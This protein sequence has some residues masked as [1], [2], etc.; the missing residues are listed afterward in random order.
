MLATQPV[1]RVRRVVGAPVVAV[2]VWLAGGARV[3]ALPGQA[4][5][6]GRLLAE[7]TRRRDW[8]RIADEAEAR[9]MAIS[10][11]GG[12]ETHGVA[13]DALAADWE[14]AL[15]WA[16]ELTLEP[17]FPEDRCRWLGR[18][19]A[20]ELESLGDQPEVK[21]AWGFLRQLYHPH[22]RALPLHGTAEGLT[23]LTGADC[24]AFHQPALGRRLIV[25]AAGDLD[26]DAVAARIEALFAEAVTPAAPETTGGE[27][28]EGADPAP[29][30]GLAESRLE[31]A[32]E[33]SGDADDAD[34]ADDAA[35]DEDGAPQA[36]L[37][38]GHLTVPRRHPDYEAL[39]LAAVVLGSGAGLTGRIPERIREREGLAYSTH[40]QTVSGA[41]L[42]PGRLVAYVGTSVATVEQA[43][44]GVR[45]EIARLVGEGIT[46]EELTE[47]RSYLLGREPFERE[48][49]R[50]WADLLAEA[51]H[52]GLPLDDPAW[53]RDRLAALDRPAVEAAI[54]RHLRPDALKVTVGIP[55]TQR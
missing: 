18:Q 40:V 21:T 19:A 3:E 13:L 52:Y 29:P 55:T 2:R 6:A 41:G 38:L 28:P 26:A 50:Q 17:T 25:T 16:A 23:A 20:A 11:F 1:V 53:R 22:R 44:R 51:E 31:V 12:F 48:T 10:S 47:A 35:D 33:G 5:V 42:D 4:L 43:E 39:E 34:D 14:R 37:Y 15:A 32:L 27:Q 49:A 9:G 36:H 30:P 45:E 7:G 24:A 8:R 46:G 54:R